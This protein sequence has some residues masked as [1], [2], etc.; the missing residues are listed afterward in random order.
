M[1]ESVSGAAPSHALIRRDEFP[2]IFRR[3]DVSAPTGR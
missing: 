2:S 3:R 1:D